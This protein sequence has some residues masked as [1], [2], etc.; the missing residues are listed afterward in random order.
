V[1]VLLERGTDLK[2]TS[3]KGADESTFDKEEVMCFVEMFV[4]NKIYISPIAD[5]GSTPAWDW[6]FYFP[7]DG[8]PSGAGCTNSIR[9]VAYNF[10]ARDQPQVRSHII[11]QALTMARCECTSFSA[12]G[13]SQISRVGDGGAHENCAWKS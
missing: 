1:Q 7:V 4:N 11:W 13:P 12:S 5:Q 6:P 8:V 9:F 2:P 3:L 10:L